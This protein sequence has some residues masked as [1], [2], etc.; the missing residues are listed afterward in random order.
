MDN[1]ILLMKQKPKKTYG[2]NAIKAELIV[3][4]KR[5]K[6]TD[7]AEWFASQSHSRPVG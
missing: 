4:R 1:R 7:R 3:V 5:C 2:Q 6:Q